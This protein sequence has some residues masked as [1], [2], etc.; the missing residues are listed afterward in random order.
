MKDEITVDAVLENV[1]GVTE[2]VDSILEQFE[3]PMKAQ[4]QIDVAIDEL[5]SNIANYAYKDGKGKA[6]IKIEIDESSLAVKLTFIDNGIPYN[7]LMHE[8]PDVTLS[9]EEREI[10]GLGI[11]IVKKSMD[12]VSYEYRDEQNILTIKKNF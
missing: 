12:D 3:C 9:A 10:G 7:P 5:F 6:T 4:M 1:S 11:F 2:F 8:D